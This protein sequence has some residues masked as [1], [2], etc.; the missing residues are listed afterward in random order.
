M[1]LGL[2]MYSLRQFLGTPEEFIQTL[3]KVKSAGYTGVELAGYGP[4][5]PVELAKIIREEG[6]EVWGAHNSLEKLEET[7]TLIDE[8]KLFNCPNA[9]LASMPGEYHN[10]EGYKTVAKKLNQIGAIL[11]EAGITLSYHNHSFELERFEGK[12]GLEILYSESDPELVQA[13]IDTFWI[14]H[15]GGDPALYIRKMADRLPLVHLK[16]MVIVNGRRPHEA[17]I[18]EGNINFP[19]ILQACKEA[20][21]RYYIVEQD[22]FIRDPFDS[23]KASFDNVQKLVKQL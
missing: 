14:Q 10:M 2:Q 15:G 7:Q 11:K 6:L 1:E 8:L 4:F 20:K 16:D 22:N 18:G 3:K 13:E 5:S 9:T 12:T 23:I 19:A 17:A 21:V